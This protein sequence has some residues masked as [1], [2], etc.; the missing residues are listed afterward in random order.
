MQSADLR[1]EPAGIVIGEV[2]VDDGELHGPVVAELAA[3]VFKGLLCRLCEE[4]PVSACL[5]L[6]SRSG[7]RQCL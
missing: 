2:L 6:R 3:I 1:R 7:W 4:R 5:Q